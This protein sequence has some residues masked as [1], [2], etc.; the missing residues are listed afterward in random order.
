[1]KA[2]KDEIKKD[3]PD[4]KFKVTEMARVVSEGW[5]IMTAEEKQV[6]EKM[7]QDDNLR[8]EQDLAKAKASIGKPTE[9]KKKKKSTSK[10]DGGQKKPFTSGYLVFSNERR[11]HY[12]AQGSQLKTI[13]LTK[14]FAQEWNALSP[15]AK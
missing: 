5:K 6:Y 1:M 9:D 8:Y 4:A 10:A 11:T 12:K 13:E 14:V 2:K 3:N 7:A 15:D